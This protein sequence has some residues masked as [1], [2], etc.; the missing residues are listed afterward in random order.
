V[1][2]GSVA[3]AVAGVLMLI[4]IA[5]L[6]QQAEYSS[7]RDSISVLVLLF[8]LIILIGLPPLFGW[9]TRVA[10]WDASRDSGVLSLLFGAG[11]VLLIAGAGRLGI[12]LLRSG[13]ADRR[14]VEAHGHLRRR[15]DLLV[16]VMLLLLLG[17]TLLS[18]LA[19]RPLLDRVETAQEERGSSRQSRVIP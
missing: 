19:V 3:H 4:G 16:R 2:I 17:A 7:R 10:L 11:Q 13:P 6:E 5:V 9:Y 12:G 15:A 14:D 1:L 18:G 8:G